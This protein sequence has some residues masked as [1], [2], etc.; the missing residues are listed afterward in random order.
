MEQI[1]KD[2]GKGAGRW[3]KGSR[4]QKSLGATPVTLSLFR[5]RVAWRD[6]N[7]S[8]VATIAVMKTVCREV[9]YCV[10]KYRLALYGVCDL[11][12]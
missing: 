10:M 11:I 8:G 9:F 2:H 1:S 4:S 7:K 6:E 5:S 3:G 12:E